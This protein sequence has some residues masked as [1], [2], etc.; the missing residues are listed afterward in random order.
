MACH[1]DS[2]TKFSVAVVA[3]RSPSVHDQITSWIISIGYEMGI[4]KC[5]RIWLLNIVTKEEVRHAS[6]KQRR[7]PPA[8]SVAALETSSHS[9]PRQSSHSRPDRYVGLD[10]LI[11]PKKLVHSAAEFRPIRRPWSKAQSEPSKVKNT[12]S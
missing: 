7:E 3:N 12:A 1:L 8:R 5:N 4:D 11:R 6:T 10:R 9:A 2:A